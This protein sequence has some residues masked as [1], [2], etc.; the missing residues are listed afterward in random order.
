MVEKSN[1]TDLYNWQ[2]LFYGNWNLFKDAVSN[3]ATIFVYDIDGILANSAKKVFKN[4]SIKTG[5]NVS[6]E[7]ATGWDYLTEIATKEKLSPEVIAAAESDWYDPDVLRASQRFLHIKPTVLRTID[8]AGR[9][10]NYVLTSRNPGL[11]DSTFDWLNRELPVFKAE[12]VLIREDKSIDSVA[13][14]TQNL[15]RLS[16][17]APWV[18]FIDDAMSY[19]KGALEAKL[20]N[21]VVI[22]I[23]QG[24]EMPDFTHDNL[25]VIKR[26]PERLQ[27][28]Y[29]LYDA[30]TRAS[31]KY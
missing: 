25:I 7:L 12:N 31:S 15:S 28:M 10:N 18:V 6:P 24:L 26:Y 22:N 21:L 23:P 13:F 14:K 20:P 9:D 19:I 1:S 17:L 11:K 27:A 2:K 29:P 16:S 8:I 3:P 4:F 5:I 30:I